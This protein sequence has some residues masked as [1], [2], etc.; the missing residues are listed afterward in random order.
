MDKESTRKMK[1]R[2]AMKYHSLITTGNGLNIPSYKFVQSAQFWIIKLGDGE[3]Y[4][5]E[6]WGPGNTSGDPGGKS[7]FVV[8]KERLIRLADAPMYLMESHIGVHPSSNRL[9]NYAEA[10]WR[11]P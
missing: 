6:S 7:N 4:S 9:R 3:T 2:T 1:G 10:L 8:G 5:S 11:L